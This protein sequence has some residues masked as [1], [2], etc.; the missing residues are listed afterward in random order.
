MNTYLPAYPTFDNKCS[1]LTKKELFCLELRIPSTGD[2]ELDD[3]IKTS[4]QK[5]I[6]ENILYAL[7]ANNPDED[8]EMI[9]NN[10]LFMAETFLEPESPKEHI[11]HLLES[12]ADEVEIFIAKA[13]GWVSNELII[14]SLGLKR[15]VN[16][17]NHSCQSERAFLNQIIMR[18]LEDQQRVEFKRESGQSYYR[19]HHEAMHTL[20]EETD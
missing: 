11:Q 18:L 6:E 1:G 15:K 17:V 4:N 9:V 20:Q 13:D 12:M 14:N 8:N 3:L 5:R 2:T 19:I 16:S 7:V 10:A